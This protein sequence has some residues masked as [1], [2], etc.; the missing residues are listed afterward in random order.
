MVVYGIGDYSRDNI[1]DKLC[2]Y[3]T[4][5]AEEMIHNEKQGYIYYSLTER[6]EDKR[7]LS[8][9]HCLE[10]EG[11]LQIKEHKWYGKAENTQKV[12]RHCYGFRVSVK[13]SADLR[14][15]KLEQEYT[16][17]C[18]HHSGGSGHSGELAHTLVVARGEVVCNEGHHTLAKTE[19]HVHRKHIDLL[20]NTDSRDRH[21]T[22]Q[23]AVAGREVVDN[24]V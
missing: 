1:R 20:C 9:T 3:D 21:V 4:V 17:T 11:D 2:P 6:G 16:R 8:H 15:E 13:Y 12:G 19:A 14:C 18:K 10:A 5:K 24:D 7:L 23:G 22:V